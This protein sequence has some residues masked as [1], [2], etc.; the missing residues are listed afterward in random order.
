MT[1]TNKTK[2][3]LLEIITQK[4]QE[5]LDLKEDLRQLEKCKMYE[6]LTDEI[7]DVYEKLTSKGFKSSEALDITQTMIS[8]GQLPPRYTR[9]GYISYR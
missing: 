9:I 6:D 7:R 5:I 4:E 2:A 8:S 1:T 3:E